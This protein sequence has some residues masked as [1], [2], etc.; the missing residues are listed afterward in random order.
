[1]VNRLSISLDTRDSQSCQFPS[2]RTVSA[3]A[4]VTSHHKK[5]RVPILS[6]MPLCR[7]ARDIP[8]QTIGDAQQASGWSQGHGP[9]TCEAQTI[10]FID[11]P[12]PPIPALNLIDMLGHPPSHRPNR[13]GHVAQHLDRESSPHTHPPCA[14]LFSVGAVQSR[15]SAGFVPVAR[16]SAICSFTEPSCI[17]S[18]AAN[19]HWVAAGWRGAPHSPP[20]TK[21][22]PVLQPQRPSHPTPGTPIPPSSPMKPVWPN[23]A[24]SKQGTPSR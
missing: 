2:Q 13:S 20:K 24:P 10:A 9:G 11:V 22:Y 6:T 21:P 14:G 16:V 4:S 8:R 23:P 3:V 1:M 5:K 7:K 18:T 12:V 15:F 17:S 19:A